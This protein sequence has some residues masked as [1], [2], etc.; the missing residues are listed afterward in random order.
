MPGP[1]AAIVGEPVIRVILQFEVGV[2]G[3]G[4]ELELDW[5]GSEEVLRQREQEREQE[6]ELVRGRLRLA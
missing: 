1:G 6:G 2:A 5:E 3:D 4:Q